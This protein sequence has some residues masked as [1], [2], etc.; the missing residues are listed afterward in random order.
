MWNPFA[1]ERRAVLHSPLSHEACFE[2]LRAETA[3]MWNPLALWTHPV[4]GRVTERGFRIVR[5]MRWGR[6]SMQTEA[7][8]NWS[9]EGNG[10][11]IDVSFAVQ[12]RWLLAAWLGAMMLFCVVWMLSPPVPRPGD[13]PPALVRFLPLIIIAVGLAGIALGRWMSRGD[14]AFL[15][16][17][18]GRTLECA[19]DSEPIS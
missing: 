9:A 19:P 16:E 18:L 8:G 7:S 2:R 17:L 4:R 14:T 12:Q 3:S 15:L 11:R 6:N 10:T 1:I 13:L 5:A